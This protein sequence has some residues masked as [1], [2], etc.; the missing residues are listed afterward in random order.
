MKLWPKSLG[1]QLIAL[2]LAAL[3]ISQFVSL[4]IFAGER[5]GA[6]VAQ[7]RVGIAQRT[8][9]LV[10]L[11]EAA[12]SD[13]QE[14]LTETVSSPFLRYWISNAPALGKSGEGWADRQLLGYMYDELGEGRRIFANVSRIHMPRPPR[15]RE[16]GRPEG[17]RGHDGDDGEQAGAPP[18]GG[19]GEGERAE[20]P[21]ER[22]VGDEARVE[23][24]AEGRGG[25]RPR[26]RWYSPERRW[27]EALSLNV[28]VELAGGQWLNLAGR[29]RLPQRSFMPV[30]ASIGVMALAIIIVVA[31]TVRR[32]TRPLR[33]LAGA[34]DRLGRGED[35]ERLPE[36][37]PSEVRGTV[38][39]FN[40]MQERLTRFVKDRT[41]MLAAISHDLR[42]PITSLRIRAEFI[43]DEENRERII[44]T[45][46]EMQRM[47]EATLAFARDEAANEPP[48]KVDLGEYLDAIAQDYRDM[49]ADVQFDPPDERI[50]LSCRPDSLRRALR[51]LVD[52]AVRYGEKAR[53]SLSAGDHAA[54]IV[55]SDEGPGIPQDKLK[56]V[57]EPFVRLEESR[58]EETGGI[59]LGLSIARSIVHAHGGTL[60]LEN[61]KGRGLSA[62]VTLPVDEA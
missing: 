6:L 3:V 55:I 8:A 42:T 44:A 46:D 24:P 27:R 16:G 35:V 22:D 19:N 50:V 10:E 5:H 53:V 37:G 30:L 62:R 59:G 20:R 11:L 48:S 23:R 17:R 14:R 57:F 49:G 47:T 4:W 18:E 9:S 2:L 43:E 13:L 41:K 61:G 21:A 40:V 32:L 51:N 54:V 26:R 1:G 7:A 52:N 25:D 36:T 56:D 38:A 39:A 29:F 60:E 15:D 58:S 34:A 12:P 45:L 28:S 33:D 31:L